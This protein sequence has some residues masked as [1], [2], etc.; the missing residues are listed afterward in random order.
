MTRIKKLIKEAHDDVIKILARCRIKIEERE[1]P[2]VLDIL[3]DMRAQ[4]GIVTVRQTRPVSE[5]VSVEG[6]RWIEMNVSYL[7]EVVKE[8]D[9]FITILESIKSVKG[10]SMIKA[11]E[12]EDDII[13]AKLERK[14]IIL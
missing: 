5:I 2:T 10:V 1:D 8:K 7:P 6:H 9:V 11:I 14:P 12:H 3:T 4:N 13:N